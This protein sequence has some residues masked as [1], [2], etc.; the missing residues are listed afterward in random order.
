MAGTPPLPRCDPRQPASGAACTLPG[1]R[2]EPGAGGGSLCHQHQKDN[3][4]RGVTRCGWAAPVP[5]LLRAI[6]ARS[7]S[8]QV[9]AGG[10]GEE[11]WQALLGGRRGTAVC[12]WRPGSCGGTVTGQPTRVEE[13]DELASTHG[14]KPGCS[15]GLR[16]L[17]A[18]RV[19]KAKCRVLH[20]G[21]NNP[22]Q[23]YRL[24][25]EW[26][27]SCLVEKDLGVLV[28][29]RLNMSQQCAQVAKKANSI[30]ACV[31]SSM[32]WMM[33]QVEKSLSW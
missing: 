11:G 6:Q 24:G 27:E 25:A 26:L 33:H 2:A 4:R 17:N 1:V 22:L 7:A 16:A 13:A 12:W 23:R 31:N 19:S 29:S 32:M 28:N 21:H 18:M 8:R 15:G 30:L 5:P 3:L 14:F 10:M 20:L 9:V